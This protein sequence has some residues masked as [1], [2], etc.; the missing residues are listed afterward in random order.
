MALNSNNLFDKS[1]YN[2]VGNASW[3]N[4]YGEPR[5]FTVSLKGNF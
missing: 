4:F 2:T 5:N 3:G 1:Y